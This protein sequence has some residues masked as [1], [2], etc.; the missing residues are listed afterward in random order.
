[1]ATRSMQA[2]R[3][4]EFRKGFGLGLMLVLAAL[5]G[6]GVLWLLVPHGAGYALVENDRAEAVIL[7][8]ENPDGRA[9]SIPPGGFGPSVEVDA[10]TKARIFT[11]A[12]VLIQDV[13]IHAGFQG[14]VLGRDGSIVEMPFGDITFDA[15]SH[16]GCA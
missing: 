16:A 14:F 2:L 1:M 3:R 15:Q 7:Q 5:G 12:C 9:W 11:T 13:M 6:L 8:L 10:G 4:P